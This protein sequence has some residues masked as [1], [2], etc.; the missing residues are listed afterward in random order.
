[1]STGTYRQDV[2]GN[3]NSAQD[4]FPSTNCISITIQFRWKFNL[5]SSKF[6]LLQNFAHDTT[7]IHSCHVQKFVTI[8]WP[9]IE[10]QNDILP[11]LN[12]ERKLASEMSHSICMCGTEVYID[13]LSMG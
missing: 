13:G 10:Q 6:W 4:T 7:A 2:S 3:K 5:F 12:C 8:W 1:M 11:N 9:V